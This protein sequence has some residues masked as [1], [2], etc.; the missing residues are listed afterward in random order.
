[1]KCS[2]KDK[3]TH[4][5]FK[6]FSVGESIQFSSDYK[7]VVADSCIQA[8]KS[9]G[10]K[11]R[12]N[13]QVACY[14][15]GLMLIKKFYPQYSDKLQYLRDLNR[16][17]L[18]DIQLYEML[19]TL[20]LKAT[21][22]D[23]YELLPE[24][25]DEIKRLQKSHAVPE[26]YEIRSVMLFGISECL[27]SER[28]CDIIASGDYKRLGEMMSISHNGDRV[29]KDGKPYDYSA[30]DSYLKGLIK[31]LKN[32][33]NIEESR[34]INQG[35]GYACSTPEIDGLVDL[36]CSCPGVLGAQIAGAGLGGS[37][38]MLVESEKADSLISAL[39]FGYYRPRGI[40]CAAQVCSPSAGSSV[41]LP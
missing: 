36:A 14:E 31:N 12:F 10:S 3:V 20:P 6:P 11:D 1:M 40:N 28:A 8:K 17:G 7:I 24:R 4:M 33:V 15:F 16:I 41:V 34:I 13:Q 32:G 35:G 30:S 39:D 23:L 21:S 37:V 29:W 38:I 26:Y 25:I 27:R 22:A 18:T 9:E 2:S 5:F 19:L